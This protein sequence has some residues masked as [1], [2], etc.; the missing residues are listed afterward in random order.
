S[1]TITGSKDSTISNVIPTDV[2]RLIKDSKITCIYLNGR[3]AYDLFLKYNKELSYMAQYLP[4]TSPAN[5]AF[6][7]EDLFQIWKQIKEN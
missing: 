7:L 3:K 4:S 2:S 6:K 5:A 1:C